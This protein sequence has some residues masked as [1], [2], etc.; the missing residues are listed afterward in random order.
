MTSNLSDAKTWS[1]AS[2][3]LPPGLNLGSADGVISGLPA[4]PGAYSFTVQALIA[5]GRSDTKSLTIEVRDRL[6][7]SRSGD[8][9]PRVVRTEVGVELDGELHSGWRFRRLHL[10]GRGRPPA[11]SDPR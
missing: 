6:T 9:E 5:D 4:A 8:F 10:V 2:G 3:A 7:L 11:G 1:I